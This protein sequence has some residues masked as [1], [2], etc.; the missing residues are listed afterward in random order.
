MA[1]RYA[2]GLIGAVVSAGAPLG[3]LVLRRLQHPTT[4]RSLELAAKEVAADPVGYAY[5]GISTCV[6]FSTFGFLIGRQADLLAELSESDGLTG[7]RNARGFSSRLE[8]EIS[9]FDR[10]HEPLALLFLDLDG[11]KW[12]N[13]RFGHR[14]GDLALRHV[15]NSI[16]AELRRT[17]TGARW[18]GDEFAILAPNTSATAAIALA[19]R[20]RSLVA[21]QNLPWQPTASI[22]V[23]AVDVT[24]SDERIDSATLMYRADAALYEAKRQGGNMVTI[25]P[26]TG[27]C[28]RQPATPS[29]S[30]GSTEPTVT[31]HARSDS[32]SRPATDGGAALDA[33]SV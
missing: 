32:A 17:D 26:S 23:A 22:G 14:T 8:D 33:R 19:E 21:R 4:S 11:L 7:L 15:A 5:V 20:V 13:D 31:P 27:I 18:G 1:R 3:L 30:L 9:R 28:V 16:R 10:Y 2:Y 6:A 29:I 12:I 24:S 25:Q